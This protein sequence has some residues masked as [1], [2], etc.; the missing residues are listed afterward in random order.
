MKKQSAGILLFRGSKA[1]LEVFLV[2]PGGPF[3]ARRDA[4]AWSIP[5]GEYSGDEDALAAA[6]R[7]FQEETGVAVSGDFVSLGE[8]KQAGGKRVK[9]WA[10]K[11]DLNPATFKSN[12]FELE[13][14]QRSG[15][16]REFPE[17]D[18]GNW[19]SLAVARGKIVK[20]QEEL[21]T[22]LVDQLE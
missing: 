5:K 1:D 4:G 8:V 21:L 17:V 3:W 16:I 11:H 9:A 15:K 14:P 19:F 12:T 10:L 13:W 2:H 6:K 22:R 18:A 7:E 20:A